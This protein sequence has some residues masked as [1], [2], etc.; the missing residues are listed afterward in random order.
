MDH[1]HDKFVS[2]LNQLYSPE[3]Y[4]LSIFISNLKTGIRQYLRLFKP[5]ILVEGYLIAQQVKSIVFNTPK[6]SV[7]VGGSTLF[8]AHVP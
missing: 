6:G 4:A 3:N 2:L 7:S 5:K 8:Q 1:Y